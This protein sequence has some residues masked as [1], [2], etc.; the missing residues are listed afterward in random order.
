MFIIFYI[1]TLVYAST[2]VE[3][4]NILKFTNKS[5]STKT[6]SIE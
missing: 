2:V 6:V 3:K 5:D 4:H 1:L